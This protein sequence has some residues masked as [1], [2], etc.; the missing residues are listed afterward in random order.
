MISKQEL[1]EG[2]RFA[3]KRGAAAARYAKDWDHQLGHKWTTR[4][5]F[6]HVAA[7]AG[8]LPNLYPLFGGEML[9]GIGV[10]QLGQMNDQAISGV[11]GKTPEEIAQAI[12]EGHE[13]SAAYVEGLDEGEL[14][15]E[16]TLGG[17]QMPRAE[18]V[19]QIWINHQLA[20]T[21]EASARWPM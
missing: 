8:G 19:A 21:Y 9:A 12:E 13:K 3:G 14:S 11:A 4:D 15:Q 7:T 20:H 10:D 17:Y 5:A 1:A 2:I 6:S 18:L 16:I